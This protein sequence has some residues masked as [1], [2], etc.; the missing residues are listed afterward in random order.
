M[1]NISLFTVLMLLLWAMP[2]MAVDITIGPLDAGVT[3]TVNGSPA[4]QG[5]VFP[6]SA[7]ETVTFATT[8]G[9]NTYQDVIEA[10]YNIEVAVHAADYTT[11]PGTIY[12]DTDLGYT[13]Y[14]IFIITSD[15]P[16][17]FEFDMSVTPTDQAVKILGFHAMMPNAKILSL[18]S[19]A[20]TGTPAHVAE[21]FYGT[22]E[23]NGTLTIMTTCTMNAGSSFNKIVGNNVVFDSCETGYLDIMVQELYASYVELVVGTEVTWWRMESSLFFANAWAGYSF[24]DE[25]PELDSL[26]DDAML[27][28]KAR[29]PE[30]WA[31]RPATILQNTGD[32]WSFNTS[33]ALGYYD[34][35]FWEM[36]L[37][38]SFAWSC[39]GILTVKEFAHVIGPVTEMDNFSWIN[40]SGGDLYI[41]FFGDDKTNYEM[42]DRFNG[43]AGSA[44]T[45]FWNPLLTTAEPNGYG[46][47]FGCIIS[48]IAALI[49]RDGL[50]NSDSSAYNYL[51]LADNQDLLILSG[52]DNLDFEFTS[53]DVEFHQGLN[54]HWVV[55]DGLTYENYT[56][57]DS[58]FSITMISFNAPPEGGDI[59]VTAS[60]NYKTG[61]AGDSTMYL[62]HR[63]KN[64]YGRQFVKTPMTYDSGSGHWSGVVNITEPGEYFFFTVATENDDV[65]GKVLE[66]EVTIVSV[67]D[68][69]V[70]DDTTD[71][72]VDDDTADDDV[73]DDVDDDTA[74]DDDTADDD[75][76]DDVDDD[77]AA[78][79]DAA[80]DDA[81]DDD[82][83][84]DDDAGDDDN[85]GGGG[86]GCGC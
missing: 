2:A 25:L 85:G 72:D 79:D 38:G 82:A 69:T 45:D 56:P 70:D 46:Y 55:E 49:L 68:D 77:T 5:N 75:V 66:H 44:G 32:S 27:W 62:A 36:R 22:V 53:G 10:Q 20:H 54:S 58:S 35:N 6:F 73:D 24:N 65:F 33:I 86:G 15:N 11:S 30:K 17:V 28:F 67:D 4:I 61:D 80:D 31:L 1:K 29:N 71:D 50:F 7:G 34:R 43:D 83:A 9:G 40:N 39:V 16:A 60:N 74:T 3:L 12:L 13:P 18:G 47:T 41:N 19:D 78:D 59:E 63:L 21:V 76:D 81:A 8:F 26:N 37:A 42:G 57:T 51:Y 84:T 52:T 48:P 23:N 64:D 14:D